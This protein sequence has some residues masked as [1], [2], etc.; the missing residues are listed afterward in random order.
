M[1]FESTLQRAD[2]STF[3]VQI[4][5]V[6]VRD[7]SDQPL[8]RVATVQDI[9]ERRKHIAEL[10]RRT[11]ELFRSNTDL[12]QFAYVASHDLQE[13]LRAVAGCVQLLRKRYAE[14]LDDR[15]NEYI[16]FAVDGAS[17]MQRLIDDLLT[18]SRLGRKNE[19]RQV[20]DSAASLSTALAN[21]SVGLQESQAIVTNDPLPMIAT[22][23]S[24]LTNVFQNLIGNALKFRNA[25]SP[26]VHVGAIR[27][28]AAWHFSVR[29]NGIGI[30]PQYFER[31]FGIFQ[32]LHTRTEYPGTGIG[33]AMC[34]R[35]V[36]QHGGRI[37]VE[38]AVGAG[39]TFHFTIPDGD[40]AVSS[41]SSV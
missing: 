15:A 14:K 8:F 2:G 36:E 13:P 22:Y 19:K 5:V 20:T 23:S 9:S 18:Y 4:D 25:S 27:H 37:W 38:S 24:Q 41:E 6:A 3:P 35:V 11:T 17:R 40:Y 26:R 7:A 10:G 30:D 33:L 1:Q 32:R 39:S 12:E 16:E 28:E 34:K 29:D 31:I 21:L